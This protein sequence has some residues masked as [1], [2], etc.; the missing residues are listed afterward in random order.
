MAYG[1][2]GFNL[3]GLLFLVEGYYGLLNRSRGVYPCMPHKMPLNPFADPWKR[4]T[5]IRSFLTGNR[6]FPQNISCPAGTI[7]CHESC[8]G[9]SQCRH[10]GFV[11]ACGHCR[12]VDNFQVTPMLLTH[13]APFPRKLSTGLDQVSPHFSFPRTCSQCPRGTT[14]N[15]VTQCVGNQENSRYI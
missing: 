10:V 7:T 13:L 14:T 5:M 15:G 12:P 11:E 3:R 1:S 4:E 9:V 8:T 2:P 6:P